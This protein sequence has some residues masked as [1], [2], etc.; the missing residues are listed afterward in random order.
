MRRTQILAIA[1]I[2]SITPLIAQTKEPAVEIQTARATPAEI[3]TKLALQ[4]LLRKYDLA[5]YT[6]TNQ[7]V[8]EQGAMNHSF[9]V[10]TLNVRFRDS[11][12]ALLSSYVHEQLHW[13]LRDHDPQRLAAIDQLRRLYPDA[14]T[15]YP[16]GGGTPV[17]TYGHL[18]VCYLEMQ[19]DRQLLGEKR[20]K[21]VIEQ[22]PWYTWVWKT[23]VKDESTIAGVVNAEHLELP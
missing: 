2:L 1:L 9:P 17:S 15:A 6:F 18:V 11:P 22:I 13:Y 7:V 5:K 23:V 3:Q 14:P 8:I 16:E 20:T 12:D 4:A 10:I 19:A 21:A